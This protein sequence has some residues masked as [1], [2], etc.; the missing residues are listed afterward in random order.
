M[1]KQ[2]VVYITSWCPDCR[3]AREALAEW[4]VSARLVDIRREPEAALRVQELTGFESVPTFVVVADDGV[5]PVAPPA[6][7]PAGQGPRGIDRGTIL[8]EP[9]RDQMREWLAKHG[10]LRA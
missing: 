6:P 3:R 4:G 7:L 9:S 10:F 8:T 2:L 1:S 5:T